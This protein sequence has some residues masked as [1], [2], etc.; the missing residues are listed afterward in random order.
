[1]PLAAQHSVHAI[2]VKNIPKLIVRCFDT[3]TCRI[4]VK[5]GWSEWNEMTASRADTIRL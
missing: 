3:R 5:N 4:L 2:G 1:M